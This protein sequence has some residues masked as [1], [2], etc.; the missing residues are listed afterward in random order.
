MTVENFAE[1]KILSL[2]DLLER[3][4]R[5]VDAL[6]HH[7][8]ALHHH[9]DTTQRHVDTTVSEIIHRFEM[10]RDHDKA[11][12]ELKPTEK[13]VLSVLQESGGS[14]R[15]ID[16]QHFVG[17]SSSTLT[18]ALSELVEKG[19]VRWEAGLYQAASPA[20]FAQKKLEQKE[21]TK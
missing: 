15:F 21:K 4:R 12:S 1:E 9:V 19:L 2:E 3:L 16:I 8:D 5:H 18:N 13:Q 7:V 6:H 20:W 11:V 17:C 10:E 14:Q